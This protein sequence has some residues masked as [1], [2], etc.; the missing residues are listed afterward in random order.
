MRITI[1]V[2]TENRRL[3]LMRSKE[4]ETS[5]GYVQSGKWMEYLLSKTCSAGR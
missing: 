2:F 3:V 1:I 5:D 4:F